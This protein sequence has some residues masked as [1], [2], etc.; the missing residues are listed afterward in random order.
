[1]RADRFNADRCEGLRTDSEGGSIIMQRRRCYDRDPNRLDVKTR[2]KCLGSVESPRCPRSESGPSSARERG[3]GMGNSIAQTQCKQE[4]KE[5]AS[6][7]PASR[8]PKED[9]RCFARKKTQEGMVF[10][11]R[12]YRSSNQL[13]STCRGS[14]WHSPS[15]EVLET[16]EIR[17]T[18]TPPLHQV[19]RDRGSVSVLQIFL[20]SD[21]PLI[22]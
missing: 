6:P 20:I 17:L 15:P 4:R 21:L 14:C 19:R 1:M 18:S 11:E 9:R 13:A 16:S 3:N 5:R 7:S 8:T 10:E 12:R 22:R 2:P